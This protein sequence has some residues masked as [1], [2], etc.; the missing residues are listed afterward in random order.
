[1]QEN[2]I[3]RF[4][5]RSASGARCAS[6]NSHSPARAVLGAARQDFRREHAVDLEQLEFDRIAAGIGRGID[7]SQ[8]AGE[9]AAVIA[10]RFGDEDRRLRHA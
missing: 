2:W 10:G 4:E 1:M 3:P 6:G 8:R 7:K 5:Q 9:I